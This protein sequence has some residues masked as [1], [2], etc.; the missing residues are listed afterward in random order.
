MTLGLYLFA[1]LLSLV[2]GVIVLSVNPRRVINQIYFIGTLITCLWFFCLSKAIRIGET[3]APDVTNEQLLFWLRMAAA[4]PAFIVWQIALMRN[5]VL[6]N[7]GSIRQ[8]FNKTWPWFVISSGLACLAF[9][10]AYIPSHS[11]SILKLRGPGYPLYLSLIVLCG[12]WILADA[13][14]RMSRLSGIKKLECQFFVSYAALA[15]LLVIASSF[16]G[17]ALPEFSW[18]RRTAPIWITVWQGSI[19][20]A[21]CHHKVFDGKQAAALV[22]QRVLLLGMAGIGALGFNKI[23]DRW[24]NETPVIL[25]TTITACSVALICDQPLRRWLGLDTKKH[26]ARPRKKIVNWAREGLD[27]EQLKFRMEELLKEWCQTDHVKLFTL[28]EGDRGD[29]RSPNDSW[30]GLPIVTR[31]GWIT[32][33]ALLRLKESPGTSACLDF[34][35]SNKQGALLA[36]PRGSPTPSLLIALGHKHSLRPYTYPDIQLLLELAELMDNILTHA[37]IAARTAEI[38]KM[39]SATMMS[40]GLAHDLNNLTTPVSTFLLHMEERVTP[41]TV[42]AEVLHD[43]KH[44]IRV[45]QDYIRE[46]LFFARRLI[47]DHQPLSPAELLAS[48]VHVTQA[49][50]KARAVEVVIGQTTD[51]PLRADRALILRLLQNL[52]FNGID[53][54]PEGGKIT[55]SAA[56]NRH[57]HISFSVTDEGPGVPAEIVD[58]IFEPYFTT[59]DTGSKTRGLGLG[60]AISLKIGSLHGGTIT[61]SRAS[62]G[63]AVFTAT[64][65]LSPR[66]AA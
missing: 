19:V 32:P 24:F 58:R 28:K 2:N 43:A 9:S 46:S 26:L 59:K 44:S 18:L 7:F 42:E 29:I 14:R 25:I 31:E 60:L 40:R 35:H 15:S 52:V 27:E 3:S 51:V 56:T 20:W 8:A 55:L 53:A 16:A 66:P 38:E 63:G 11:T 10:E 5:A 57:G 41:G 64:L 34:I 30:P 45:M 61:V 62:S 13:M 54:T 47:P 49:R 4:V 36:V 33:E 23:F 50:A 22:G 39:E 65:P 1:A 21:I 17:Y 12:L 48:A 6:D 37:R